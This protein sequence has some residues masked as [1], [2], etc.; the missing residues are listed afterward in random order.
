MN[1]LIIFAWIFLFFFSSIKIGHSQ[2]RIYGV[3]GNHL[4]FFDY[5][6][7]EYDTIDTPNFDFPNPNG[8]FGCTI[9]P[10]N[11]RYFFNKSPG[12]PTGKVQ[13]I[14]LNTLETVTSCLLP[15]RDLIEYNCLNNSLVFNDLDGHFF[16][17]DIKKDTVIE[18]SQ[19]PNASGFIYGK[20][21][22][23][24][25]ATNCYLLNRPNYYFD[26]ID[27][28]T[29]ELIH[30]QYLNDYYGASM[31]VA[32]YQ[33]GIYYGV[34][35]DTVVIVDPYT[36]ILTPVIKLTKSFI[37]LNEQM[38]VYDQD[39]S[40]YIIPT[41]KSDISEGYYLV[42]DVKTPKIDT[43]ILQ[44]NLSVNWQQIYCMPK[45]KLSLIG[46]SLVCTKGNSYQW[47]YNG[48]PIPA[49]NT[50]IFIP[51]KSGLYKVQVSYHGYTSMS[52]EINFVMT[53]K[54]DLAEFNSFRLYPNPA[55]HI[56]NYEFDGKDFFLHSPVKL[57]I[58]DLLGSVLYSR[59]E[60]ALPSKGR[61]D[62]QDLPE[63]MYIIRIQ[64]DGFEKISKFVHSCD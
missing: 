63:G 28:F 58:M 59:I 51:R 29:G 2:T 34:Y 27:A 1:R 22:V 46:D 47:F 43:I 39:S 35:K 10:Y 23:Y 40:K 56:L 14:N 24:N 3:A 21:Y 32:D 5:R 44:P 15:K 17:Y 31:L 12:T 13:C 48:N 57:E 62:L 19:V 54:R 8:S 38:P 61:I 53:G 11:G 52:N 7:G 41:I 20:S 55:I 16:S 33:T 9:D 42:V 45:T 60:E 36:G 18:L 37:H 6:T 64:G 4:V 50:N 26:I 49:P 30:S 25:A